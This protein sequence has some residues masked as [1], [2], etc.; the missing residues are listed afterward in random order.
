M[1]A[2]T[3]PL[4]WRYARAQKQVEDDAARE[5]FKAAARWAAMHSGES[6]VGPVDEWHESGLPLGG[7]GCPEVAE[8][9]V[10]EFAAAMGRSTESGRRY[11]SQAV[12]GCYRLPAAGPGWWPGE[13]PAWKLAFI[14]ER[15]HVS[16]PGGGGVR[17]R[18]VA[19]FAHKIG[20]AQLGR[21]IEE[22]KARFDPEQTEAER[23]AAAEAGHFD[24]A[25]AE[26]GVNGR[27]RVDGDLDL[28]D[29]LDLEAAVAADAHHQLLLGST[30]SLDVRRAIA[31][32][33]LARSQHTLD[34]T[35]TAT[36][37]PR[38]RVASARWCCTSTSNTPPSSAPAASPDSTRPAARS[39]PSR[40]AS[41]APNPTPRSPSNRSS[42]SPSTS[43]SAPT[44]PPPGSSS[45]P[46]CATA[47]A[48]SRSASAPPKTA[49]A[50]TASPRPS[51]GG[52]TCTCNQAPCC[53]RHH[54]AKTTGGWTY[55]TV[56]P[57]VYLWRSPL[58]YQFLKDHTGTLDVTPDD[59]RLR[60]A[61]E[62]RAHFG[63]TDRPRTLTTP[64]HTPLS[65]T[66]AGSSARCLRHDRA[67]QPV[68]G[69]RG[70]GSCYLRNAPH[71]V[72]P[73]SW[74]FVRAASSTGSIAMRRNCSDSDEGSRSTYC[75][76]KR[77]AASYASATLSARSSS[78]TARR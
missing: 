36:P 51:D 15:T 52:P 38:P 77:Y 4:C 40:S 72:R 32:G 34:L 3:P 13:L 11:L 37:A 8:F 78:V 33:N 5:V 24:I 73:R 48:C 69:S 54:R 62:F 49:T 74:L 35:P 1:G 27:V 28:A 47:P 60:L 16:V 50:N 55:I 70:T 46:S 65:T 26:V 23:L 12:E 75:Q 17:G 31:V 21:L 42:T 20:P 76:T 45:R 71:P 25:L 9:A 7:E 29:A 57:G 68:L 61:R 30:E 19:P 44:K 58:G 39:P 66:R 6:L 67:Y 14:A 59:E 2:T 53:R 63:D 22:A 56:E 18:H 64:P 10:I 43:R 41:G